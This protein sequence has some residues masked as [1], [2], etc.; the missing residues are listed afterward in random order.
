MQIPSECEWSMNSASRFTQATNAIM[1]TRP[2]KIFTT[3]GMAEEQA[4]DETVMGINSESSLDDYW[5]DE[6]KFTETTVQPWINGFHSPFSR[7]A[8]KAP[9]H[10]VS[11]VYSIIFLGIGVILL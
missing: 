3:E 6:E 11:F 5:M 8:S 2:S 1:S 4:S 10:A 7:S 9:H